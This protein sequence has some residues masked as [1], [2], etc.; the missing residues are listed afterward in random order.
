MLVA[1]TGWGHLSEASARSA[2]SEYAKASKRLDRAVADAEAVVR[3]NPRNASARVAL[4]NAYLAAGRFGFGRDDA[5]G[6]RIAR[7]FQPGEL[8][9]AWP[10]R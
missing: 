9:C 4:G 5:A 10:W 6:C 3:R 7:R 1:G 8:R 2:Q